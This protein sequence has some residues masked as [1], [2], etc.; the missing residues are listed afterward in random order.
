MVEPNQRT[1]MRRSRELRSAAERELVNDGDTAALLIFYAAECGLKARY[2]SQYHLENTSAAT[3]VAEAAKSFNHN[4]PRLIEALRIPAQEIG[5]PPTATFHR[6]GDPC[7][8][9]QVHAAWRYGVKIS[10][11]QT[12]YQWLKSIVDWAS[13]TT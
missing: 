6:T 12:V 8:P 3:A 10:N 1:L 4:L 2:L 9:P 5:P 13:K 11:T 7:L